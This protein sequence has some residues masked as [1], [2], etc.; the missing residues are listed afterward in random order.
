MDTRNEKENVKLSMKCNTQSPSCCSNSSLMWT[1]VEGR[2]HTQGFT[3]KVYLQSVQPAKIVTNVSRME[4]NGAFLML[5]SCEILAAIYVRQCGWR[6]LVSITLHPYCRDLTNT[7]CLARRSFPVSIFYCIWQK[8]GQGS[9]T[10]ISIINISCLL[11]S[12]LLKEKCH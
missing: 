10:S 8:Y 5:R 7:R 9:K 6:S 11:N 1:A 12:F 4:R 2:R 3:G